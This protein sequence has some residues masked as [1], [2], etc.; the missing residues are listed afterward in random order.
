MLWGQTGAAE[1]ARMRATDGAALQPCVN[2]LQVFQSLIL[3]NDN[4]LLYTSTQ[5]LFSFFSCI[6]LSYD[7]IYY[8][9]LS[10]RRWPTHK[11]YKLY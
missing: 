8:I 4:I 9:L 10:Q 7:I 11:E 1:G 5:F 6:I 2:V 3:V